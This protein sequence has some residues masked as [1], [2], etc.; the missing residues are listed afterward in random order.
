[1]RIEPRHFPV[2]RC[3]QNPEAGRALLCGNEMRLTRTAKWAVVGM[4]ADHVETADQ[5]DILL[6]FHRRLPECC[7]VNS[8]ITLKAKTGRATPA[9]PG[10]YAGPVPS[11]HFLAHS[12]EIWPTSLA[13][14][15]SMA[16]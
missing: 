6:A 15:I 13:Q 7:R 11:A 14:S 3:G 8:I 4:K 9:A 5:A 10:R 2:H 16:P 12:A 1:M